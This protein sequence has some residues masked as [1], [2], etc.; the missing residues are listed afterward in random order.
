MGGRRFD[1]G[2]LMND[3]E[4]MFRRS[5][6]E[7]LQLAQC[8]GITEQERELFVWLAT[9]W[10]RVADTLELQASVVGPVVVV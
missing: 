10:K 9:V 2:G 4:M 6:E 5:A 3:Y 1:A 7:C 8:L